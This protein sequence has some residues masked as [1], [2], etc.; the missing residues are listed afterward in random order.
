[1]SAADTATTTDWTLR[2]RMTAKLH[3]SDVGGNR[4]TAG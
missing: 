4:L 3:R 2:G 1:V